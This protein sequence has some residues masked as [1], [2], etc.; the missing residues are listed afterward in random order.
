MKLQRRP[1]IATQERGP[2]T[3]KINSFEN[4]YDSGIAEEVTLAGADFSGVGTPRALLHAKVVLFQEELRIENTYE[5]ALRQLDP[6]SQNHCPSMNFP[7]MLGADCH[8]LPDAP[9]GGRRNWACVACVEHPGLVV[10]LS[11]TMFSRLKRNPRLVKRKRDDEFILRHA[12]SMD[13]GRQSWRMACPNEY[14]PNHDT[15][16]SCRRAQQSS[17]T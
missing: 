2:T 7:R 1:S 8:K 12:R 16:S 3:K 17:R 6:R 10:A 15:I 11:V 5:A 9:F 13:T 14:V 4:R